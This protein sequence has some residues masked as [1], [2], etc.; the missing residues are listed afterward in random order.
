M[1]NPQAR[2]PL[3][4]LR[5]FSHHA[6]SCFTGFDDPSPS[7]SP[8]SA[9]R[10]CPTSSYSRQVP[11]HPHQ[12]KWG[13]QLQLPTRPIFPEV[14]GHR[15][16]GFPETGRRRPWRWRHPCLDRKK[17]KPPPFRPGNRRVVGLHE[18]SHPRLD[19]ATRTNEPVSNRGRP[20]P[21]GHLHL[22]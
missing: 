8:R 12:K 17:P 1:Q 7:Q 11:S 22:V 10:V 19:R 13:L 16:G 4:A 6:K 14:H 15:S 18:P 2:L 5:A 20:R 9:R 21:G 3:K